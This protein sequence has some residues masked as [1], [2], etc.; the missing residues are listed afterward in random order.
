MSHNSNHQCTAKARPVGLATPILPLLMSLF[1]FGTISGQC[2]ALSSDK[3]EPIHIRSNSAERDET[4]G[5]TIYKGAVEMV[6]GTLQILANEVVIHSTDN[7]ISMIIATGKPAQYQQLPAEDKQLVIA[8]GERI[9]YLMSDDKIRLSKNASLQ[10]S[11][12]TTMTGDTI[13][14]DMKAAIVRAGSDTTDSERIHMI[15]PPKANGN[16]TPNTQE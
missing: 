7:K 16:E 2:L 14:Y 12:G 13:N 5:I 3:Q 6:Q 1:V 15:I 10:Q 4:T 9:E 11:D 8:R